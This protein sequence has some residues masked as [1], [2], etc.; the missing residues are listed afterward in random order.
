MLSSCDI[1]T[2]TTAKKLKSIRNQQTLESSVELSGVG[3]FSGL[4]I[5]MKFSPA[6]AGSGIL[7]KRIDLK[8]EPT[9]KASI[10]NVCGTPR[11]TNLG[12]GKVMIQS[13]EH[14]LSALRAFN[15]DNLI[16]E[17]DGP[18]VPAVDGSALPFVEM[19]YKGGILVQEQ[20]IE[21]KRIHK[22]I[23]WSKGDV[24]LVALPSD[25]LRISYTLS[26]PKHPILD[27]QYFTTF[28]DSDIYENEIARCRTFSLYEEIVP[29]LDQGMIKGGSLDSGVIIKGS[30]I[31]NPDGLRFPNEMARHKVLD[32]IGDI[33]LVAMPFSAHIIAVRSG[34]FS[35][36]MF[37]RLIRETISKEC[38]NVGK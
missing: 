33:S 9:F 18:E 16:I 19:I 10:E 17:L 38:E 5:N 34:H 1:E 32:L 35:N 15:L 36:T 2:L 37:A 29:L 8:N 13:V 14:V 11:C 24:H 31:M 3:L 28:L 21:V 23:F 6:P 12:D 7:F 25:E 20:L 27:S 4:T 30:Q 22:P 26:Y